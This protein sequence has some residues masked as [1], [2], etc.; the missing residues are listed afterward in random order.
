MPPLITNCRLP[1]A[2]AAS[3]PTCR[4]PLSQ[5]LAT[6]CLATLLLSLASPALADNSSELART[7]VRILRSRCQSC[8]GPQQQEGELRVDSLKALQTGGSRGP[9]LTS[10]DAAV[11]SLLLRSVVGDDP[12][13][14]MPPKQPLTQSEVT[15]LKLWLEAGVPW[16]EASE[17]DTVLPPDTGSALADPRNPIHQLFGGERLTLWSLRPLQ[18]AEVL[19]S[20]GHPI[21]HILQAELAE[22]GLQ[23]SPPADR[24][25]L[26]RRASLDLTGLLPTAADVQQFA[27]DTAA[28]AWERAIDRLLGSPQYGERQ[29]RL[30]LDVVR[31]A[32]TNG[33]ERDEF[34]PEMWRYRDYVVRSFNAD[35]P[36]SQFVREQLA[37]DELAGTAPE[38]TADVDA[39]IA[40][41]FLRL[42]QWDSTAAIFQEEPRLQAEIQADLTNTTASAFLGL[43]MSCCQCHDHKYDP[44]SQADHYRLRAFFASATPRND[45]AAAPADVRQRIETV[46]AGIEA[47]RTALQKERD[48]LDEQSTDARSRLQKQLED[49]QSQLLSHDHALGVVDRTDGIPVTRILAQGDFGSPGDETLPGFPSVLDPHPA[50][51]AA[52]RQG[53]TGRR[54]ALAD[55][56]VSP[57]N[58]WAARVF[59]NRIWQQHFGRGLV[60]T[61][62]DFGITGSTPVHLPLLDW[63]ASEFIRSGW[64]VKS[65]H[66]M[67]LT[68]AAWQQQSAN[69][70]R[71]FAATHPDPENHLF[72]RQ[73][74][75]RLDAE[76]V[77]DVL[78]QTSALLREKSGG[79]PVWP[80]VPQELLEAQPA[81][82]EA[83]EGKDDGRRQG[84]YTDPVDETDVRSLYLVRKRCLPIPF[85]QVFDLPDTTSSCARRDE[86]V[87]APQAIML[88]NSPETARCCTAL[89]E[90]VRLACGGQT[91]ELLKE[92]PQAVV[93]AACHI[94]F[95]RSADEDEQTRAIAFLRQ[96]GDSAGPDT[97]LKEFCRALLNTNEFLYVD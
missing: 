25:T 6:L 88:L 20:S 48:A 15:V 1:S 63:L 17:A 71:P 87:V 62:N 56:I 46:N 58:P 97:A 39:L 24:R 23:F 93:D 8:H 44:L 75:R 38:T 73:N 78:L 16:P 31:Y 30:W 64:S 81:I 59:V 92:N 19:D 51:I 43:T 52:P 27:T 82:L 28:D 5:F 10:P 76:T 84:W 80:P 72:W 57:G 4:P 60:A 11:S 36:F 53:T 18:P 85:L 32:D 42:G 67:I 66:R 68:S 22:H 90:R 14:Q 45:L 86:T 41:G 13:L 54:L 37:G 95:Q 3:T 61:A 94:M 79:P 47:R 65:L 12:D 83:L 70:G 29:A 55:W 9:A 40:T 96:L 7:A 77:R 74:L 69:P 2:R 21:D 33:Y 89:A 35:K 91:S 34:R 26:L 50:V 49:L